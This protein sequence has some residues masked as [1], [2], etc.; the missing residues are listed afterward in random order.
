MLKREKEKLT[1]LEITQ[2]KLRTASYYGGGKVS[3]ASGQS[4][5]SV[6]N[7]AEA[8][9]AT[10]DIEKDNMDSMIASAMGKYEYYK[11]NIREQDFY[12]RFEKSLQKRV[13]DGKIDMLE[14]KEKLKLERLHWNN[15][16]QNAKTQLAFLAFGDK[17]TLKKLYSAGPNIL[18]DA[19]ESSKLEDLILRFS[20]NDMRAGWK[21]KYGEDYQE[22]AS[23]NK[24]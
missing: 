13:N 4:A 8:R 7:I 10:T 11:D 12:K 5:K 22:T 19:F 20:R 1:E 24:L 17:Q 6:K 14:K 16:K 21:G 23:K 18:I 2:S 9:W 3:F 15:Q